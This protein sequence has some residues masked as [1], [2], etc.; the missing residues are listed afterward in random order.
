MGPRVPSERRNGA[1][2]LSNTDQDKHGAFTAW[3][4]AQGVE[5]DN[6]APKQLPGRGLGLVATKKIKQGSRIL[7][8][9]ESTIFKPQN[10]LLKQHKLDKASSQAKL[11]I[12][13]LAHFAP[14]D[15]TERV[16]RETWPTEDDMKA[17][18]PI[19]WPSEPPEALLS[20]IQAPLRRQRTDYQRDWLT[21]TDAVRKLG[22]DET[23]FKYYWMIVNSRSFHWAP[24]SGRPGHMVLCPF[25]DYLNHGPTGSG[26][27]VIQ[28]SDGYEVIAQRAYSKSIRS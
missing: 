14:Q 7:F 23:D 18:M 25:I 9:P 2:H 12:S 3:A 5:I 16:W 8:I 15:A 11:A 28:R 13:S 24:P 1:R 20:P 6:V 10:A 26:C 17:C 21:C 27:E 4:K 19:Y 22:F